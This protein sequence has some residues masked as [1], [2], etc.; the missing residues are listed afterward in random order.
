MPGKEVYFQI[1]M[2]FTVLLLCVRFLVCLIRGKRSNYL[3][4]HWLHKDGHSCIFEPLGSA[5]RILSLVP[6]FH[7]CQSIFGRYFL[8]TYKNAR[9]RASNTH[10][11]H[12]PS[13]FSETSKTHLP[14]KVHLVFFLIPCGLGLDLQRHWTCSRGGQDCKR[15]ENSQP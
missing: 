14:L 1:H 7:K 10:T 15:A 12:S 6:W 8:H 5:Q 2:T 13:L 3:E 11:A 4:V 9:Q